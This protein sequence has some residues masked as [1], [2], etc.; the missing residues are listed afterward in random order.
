MQVE[1]QKA[2]SARFSRRRAFGARCTHGRDMYA[3]IR[4]VSALEVSCCT[5]RGNRSN[6]C[7][8]TTTR[9]EERCRRTAKKNSN[10]DMKPPPEA[11]CFEKLKTEGHGLQCGNAPGARPVDETGYF[12]A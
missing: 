2:K 10:S 12:L 6:P 1:T 9:N 8:V 11:V 5:W 7:V 3:H 4:K